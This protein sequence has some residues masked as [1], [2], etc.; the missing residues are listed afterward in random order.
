M[1]EYRHFTH[2]PV[3]VFDIAVDPRL[4]K[5][6]NERREL[7]FMLEELVN[8]EELAFY[9]SAVETLSP[10]APDLEEWYNRAQALVCRLIGITS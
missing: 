9:P 3:K 2:A 10:H 6:E 8:S 7:L 1:N 4:E 5:A